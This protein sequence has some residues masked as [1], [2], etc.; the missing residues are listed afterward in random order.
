MRIVTAVFLAGSTVGAILLFDYPLFAIVVGLVAA[1]A[2]WEWHQLTRTT[3]PSGWNI[4]FIALVGAGV[5]VLLIFPPAL[6]W[7]VGV[8]VLCCTPRCND[9]LGLR[10]YS[11]NF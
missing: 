9:S 1:T 7:I 6:P 8:G 10:C 11:G 5:P 3:P 4:A 2:A